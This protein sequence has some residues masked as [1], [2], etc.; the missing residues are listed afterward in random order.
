MLAALF[1]LLIGVGTAVGMG[2][3]KAKEA[4][5]SEVRLK[6]VAKQDAEPDVVV[7][8]DPEPQPEPD[9]VVTPDLKPQPE[10]DVVVT[11]DPEPQPVPTAT[12]VTLDADYNAAAMAGR[13]T[14]LELPANNVAGV[15]ILNGPEYGNVTVNPDNTL[16]VVLSAT[17]ETSNLNFQVET[18]LADGTVTTHDVNL[19]VSEGLQAGGW[20][21]GDFYMLE[22]DENDEVVVEHGENHR[23]VYISGDKDALTLADIANIEGM[24]VGKIKGSFL[25]E[26]SEYGATEDMALAEDAG[27]KLWSEIT[28]K[29][30][31]PSSNW[32]LLESGHEYGGLGRFIKEGTQGESEINP[33]YIGAYGE[34]PAPAVTDSVAVLKGVNENIVV[35]G[36]DFE[37]NVTLLKGS[38]YLLDDISVS[39]SP[40]NVQNINGFTLRNSDV[41][42]SV[43]V[44]PKNPD[45]W[46]PHADRESGIFVSKSQGI[47]LENSFFD[48]NGW[49]DGY[50]PAGSTE[51]GAPP[52]MYSHNV[53][54]QGD[55]LDVTLRDNIIMRGSASGAQVR[56]GGFIE[57]NIFIDNNAGVLFG[58]G[59]DEYGGNYTLF[60]D[61][62]VTSAGYKEAVQKQ[63]ALSQGVQNGGA[64]PSLIDNI[65]THLADP[66]SPEELE[67]KSIGQGAL[68][69]KH[70]DPY[71]GDTIIH[72]WVGSKN[73]T[74][75]DAN[76]Q[77][78]E[79]LDYATLDQTTI[80]L[81]TAELLGKETATI[82][83]LADH[84]RAQA[85]GQFDDVV[86]A[87]LIIAY[88]QTGFGITPD[89]RAEA[90]TLRFVPNDLGDGVRWD[91]RLNWTTEDLPGTQDGDSVDL[92]GN[93]VYYGGTTT[94]E[95]FDFGEGGKLTVTHG[96]LQVDDHI[97][98][99]DAGAELN[100]DNAGQF[101]ANGYTDQDL[102][103]INAAGG[104]FANTD[105]FTGT[106]DLN[107]SDNAQ[108]I[109]ATDNADFALNKNSSLT[110]TGDD[111]KVGFDGDQGGTG[112]LMLAEG[113][114]LGF[115]AEDGDLGQIREFYS[116]KFDTDGPDIQSGVNLGNADLFLD[117][118]GLT[119]GS[120]ADQV[121]IEVDEVIGVFKNIEVTGL[122]SE[123]NAYVT[124]DYDAD[125]VTLSLG[126]TGAGKGEVKVGIV[127]DESDA[128]NNAELWDALTNGHG[129][130]P[131]DPPEDIPKE[132]DAGVDI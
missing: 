48:H 31:A 103:T 65:V 47:L 30:A 79:G 124:V 9:V 37:S 69:H 97:A 62:V 46:S 53:Y 17:T 72:N 1:A 99:G 50:D 105:L 89:I 75:D 80:Q 107:I 38:N 88:F 7:T 94:I 74:T 76:N 42:D 91:N 3:G 57:D 113:S 85:D 93:W 95:D 11:P 2:G 122:G 26:H 121:L 131:D 19:D 5:E 127:G 41:V 20:G 12:R 24:D 123:Q 90:E 120:A 33:I 110:I 84:L 40:V 132:E 73:L 25:A 87:D 49:A 82:A 27:I 111:A 66:N 32:L 129:T 14:T 83:D 116:G 28:G 114:T 15:K 71:Y 16:A 34:G 86:D 101:W 39:F 51:F 130:Y 98:V 22:T 60:T 125:T 77:N 70:S 102:L 119:G 118:T 52:S 58:R 54:L 21:L 64:L 63:G 104:R 115:E 106:T 68:N 128:Q 36:L 23:K 56:G 112:V 61:N 13:V 78:T 44:D 29:D 35:Q 126:E 8:P 10:P 92:G 109:L 100:I 59:G 96:Y 18:T 55:L 4:G 6:A 43:D 108:V 67:A 117:L 81:F 45:L